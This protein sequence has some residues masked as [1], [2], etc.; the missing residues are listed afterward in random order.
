MNATE[1][2]QWQAV[3]GVVSQWPADGTAVARDGSVEAVASCTDGRV[4]VVV[5]DVEVLCS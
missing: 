3:A 5:V 1:R 4:E 2:A